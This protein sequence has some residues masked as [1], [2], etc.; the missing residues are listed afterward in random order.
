MAGVRTSADG[1]GGASHGYSWGVSAN[2]LA[3]PSWPVLS[4][5]G[6]RRRRRSRETPADLVEGGQAT[7]V[8]HRRMDVD[9]TIQRP[10]ATTATLARRSVKSRQPRTQVLSN[11]WTPSRSGEP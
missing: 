2:R 8:R 9:R 10:R 11:E 6:P 4:S 1:L 3:T 5:A 7:V